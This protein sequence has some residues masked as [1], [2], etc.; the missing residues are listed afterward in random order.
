MWQCSTLAALGPGTRSP[1]YPPGRPERPLG[2]FF[3]GHARAIAHGRSRN[4]RSSAPIAGVSA[5]N[6]AEACAQLPKTSAR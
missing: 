2:Q 4:R 1:K 6:P 5:S 3:A